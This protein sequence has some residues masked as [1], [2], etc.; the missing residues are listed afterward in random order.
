MYLMSVARCAYY[1]VCV[2]YYRGEIFRKEFAQLDELRN[3]ISYVMA[4]T[5]TATHATSK[6]ISKV[7]HNYN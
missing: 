5:T 4:V 7:L 6:V 3:L 2:L 1:Y